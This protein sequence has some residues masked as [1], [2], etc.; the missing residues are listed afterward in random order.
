M[1]LYVIREEIKPRVAQI[2]VAG[3]AQVNVNATSRY[4]HLLGFGEGMSYT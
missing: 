4:I 1:S 3:I 2:L